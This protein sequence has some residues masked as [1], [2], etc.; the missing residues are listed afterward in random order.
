MNYLIEFDL[1]INILI[2]VY[3]VYANNFSSG[4][5]D[6]IVKREDAWVDITNNNNPSQKTRL[7]KKV[8]K[9]KKKKKKKKEGKP[10]K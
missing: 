3:I 7:V 5:C 10:A 9:K 4:W 1:Y 2:I 8:K 6:N